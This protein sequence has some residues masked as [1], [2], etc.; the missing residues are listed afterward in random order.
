MIP[1]PHR[2][3]TADVTLRNIKKTLVFHDWGDVSAA[4]VVVCAHGLSR[5]GRDF[6]VIA[7]RMADKGA[8]VLAVD[9]PGRGE[10][11]W[12]DHTSDYNVP[13][14]AQLIA[15]ALRAL[16][17]SRFDWI[18]TSMGGLIGMALALN[19]PG[20]MRKLVVNDVGPEIERA[21]LERIGGYMRVAPPPFPSYEVLFAAAQFA[22]APF[23]PLTDEQKHHIVRTS[24]APGAD[25][26]WRFNTDPKISEAF[27]SSLGEPIVDLWPLWRAITQ[28]MLVLR[29]VHSDLLSAATLARMLSDNPL[30]QAHTVADT[31]HAPMLMDA[32]TIERVEAFLFAV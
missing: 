5:N 30:A 13:T 6:D 18:G 11:D 17:V 7:Q 12:L 10:S 22:I 19:A 3:T 4:Q 2:R 14:Y 29:G 28:P 8:R 1:T 20:D 32:P 9:V 21:A 15:Q 27:V 23:G 25:G 24:C 31:G 26:L 16:G